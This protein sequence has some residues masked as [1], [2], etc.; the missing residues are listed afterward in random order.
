LARLRAS[1]CD[2][3]PPYSPDRDPIEMACDRLSCG[4]LDGFVVNRLLAM[5]MKKS[6][7]GGRS[8]TRDDG[9]LAAVRSLQTLRPYCS[10]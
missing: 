6:G 8:G 1:I 3:L 4:P 10:V 2:T 7:A 9:D 5:T